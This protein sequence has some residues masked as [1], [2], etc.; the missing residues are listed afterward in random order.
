MSFARSKRP[1]IASAIVS[2]RRSPVVV[3]G[4]AGNLGSRL[5]PWLKAGGREVRCVDLRVIDHDLAFVDDL[6]ASGDRGEW[7]AGAHAVVHLAGFADPT[8]SWQEVEGP[9]VTTT[10]NVVA[11]AQRHGVER[12]VLA[13]SVWAM[14]ERWDCGGV[15]DAAVA[16]PGDRAY[17]RSK[18][19]AEAL[20]AQGAG[21]GLSVVVLRI[22]GRVAGDQRPARLDEWED[23][24]WLGWQDFLRGVDC[25]L[26]A[27]LDG[28]AT[29]N[30]VSNNPA[31]RWSLTEGR[32]LIGYVPEQSFDPRPRPGL[33]RRVRRRL[34]G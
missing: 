16:R 9:N 1:S 18:A 28:L 4:A 20:V 32:E 10:R 27:P 8:A 21:N 13:S 15:V 7:M 31:G 12:L 26:D 33:L 25:A 11:A 3:T 34:L 24:C 6:S 19:K 5:V 30:L 2:P 29:V 23:A 17:G 22:G 14:R